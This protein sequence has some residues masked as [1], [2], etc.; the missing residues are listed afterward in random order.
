MTAQQVFVFCVLA[1]T[2]A[3]FVWN[4]WRYDIVAVMALLVV[5][6]AGLVPAGK[7]LAGFG[8]PA[9]ITVA[10]VLVLSQGLIN[11]GVVDLIARLLWRVGDNPVVQVAALTGIVALLSAFMNNVAAMAL[12]MPVGITI[13]R[14]RGS[15]P[16][17]LLMPMA[18]GSLLGGMTTLIGTPPNIIIGSYR[19][20]TGLEPFRMFD[21]MPVGG[22][23]ALAGLLF[24]SLVGWRLMPRRSKATAPEELFDIS[25]YIA[26]VR[27]RDDS[28]FAGRSLHELVIAA[29]EEAE[30][31]VL[32]LV[33][34]G[35]HE[36][37]PRCTRPCVRAT[38]C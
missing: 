2:L 29:Q 17:L 11:A 7:V 19:A 18:F 23:V 28:R 33:R 9:V 16:S 25:E 4:R 32:G 22:G 24:I 27:L 31:L 38:C 34:G 36:T 10:A 12:L 3:M 14:R 15:P 35:E 26:E 13:S 5:A 30:I 21:F 6:L 1:A 20:Q 37:M 8:H